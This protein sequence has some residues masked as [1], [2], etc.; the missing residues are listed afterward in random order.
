MAGCDLTEEHPS[1]LACVRA[2]STFLATFGVTP[3]LGSDF[4]TEEDGPN[5]PEV[6][7]ISY[8]LWKSR[9]GGSAAALGQRLSLD[10]QPTRVLGVLPQNF[11]WPT[12]ARVDVIL[13]EAISAAERT[14]PIAGVVRAYARLKTQSCG[15]MGSCWR[16]NL[17]PKS[18]QVS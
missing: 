7:L 16:D 14:N 8:A 18:A 10:G 13:P 5:A 11:E 2:E 9:F 12:L 6:C 4:S 3:I 1:R 17:I 15:R